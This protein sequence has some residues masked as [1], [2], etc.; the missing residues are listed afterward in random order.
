MMIVA[1]K[2]VVVIPMAKYFMLMV[3]GDLFAPLPIFFALSVLWVLQPLGIRLRRTV[4]AL[5]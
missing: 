4:L 3:R 1:A 2:I 5:Y